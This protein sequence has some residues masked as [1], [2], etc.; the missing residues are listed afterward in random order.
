MPRQSIDE[1]LRRL[2]N[3]AE[4]PVAWVL[5]VSNDGRLPSR[6][7]RLVQW[8]RWLLKREGL[9]HDVRP[10]TRALRAAGQTVREL[11]QTDGLTDRQIWRRLS[12]PLPPWP[13][14][15]VEGFARV[16]E[17]VYDLVP[18][19]AVR[20][21]CQHC[22]WLAHEIQLPLVREVWTS[23][24]AALDLGLG[25]LILFDARRLDDGSLEGSP[26][27]PGLKGPGYCRV[28]KQQRQF[29]VAGYT[30]LPFSIWQAWQ[31]G[32]ARGRAAKVLSGLFVEGSGS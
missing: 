5:D 31:Q 20:L 18:M 24:H 22:G 11:A 14:E 7:R 26:I 4:I 2:G 21:E 19:F 28:C 16:R 25:G 23:N 32:R 1:I 30:A 15:N 17:P 13:V 3:V 8:L 29:A 6:M 27:P 12:R 10:K 9:L